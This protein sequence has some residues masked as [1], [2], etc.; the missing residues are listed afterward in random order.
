MPFNEPVAFQRKWD[1]QFTFALATPYS[2]SSSLSNVFRVEVLLVCKVA[3][4][5]YAIGDRV[6]LQ[7]AASGVYSVGGTVGCYVANPLSIKNKSTGAAE[8]PAVA[9]YDLIIQAYGR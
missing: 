3:A 9:N 5:G 1:Y 7:S 4:N 6:M 2:F 8:A